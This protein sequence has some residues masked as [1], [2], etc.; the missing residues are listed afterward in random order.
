MDALNDLRGNFGMSV[1][2]LR[3]IPFETAI[4]ELPSTESSGHHVCSL[5]FKNFNELLDYFIVREL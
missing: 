5:T 4:I 3:H 1:S 2:K